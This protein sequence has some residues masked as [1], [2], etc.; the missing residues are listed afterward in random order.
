VLESGRNIE[1]RN[2]LGEK[3]EY[4]E[5]ES[6]TNEK[7]T[8]HQRRPIPCLTKTE[9]HD[10][11]V[12]NQDRTGKKRRKS[13]PT[14]EVQRSTIV[15]GR[16]HHREQTEEA[17]EISARAIFGNPEL[18]LSVTNGNLRHSVARA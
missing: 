3:P 14:D 17:G 9:L 16:E 8:R 13:K 7:N 2:Q 10:H 18:S 15:V 11:R 6:D 5:L 1:V 4:E 12:S